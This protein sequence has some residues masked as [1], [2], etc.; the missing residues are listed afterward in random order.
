MELLN[1]QQS[2]R[3]FIRNSLITGSLFPL[4]N[5]FP[6]QPAAKTES[7]LKIYIFSK[8]LQF[9]DYKNM[10]EAA[11]EMGFDGV[12]LTVRPKGHVLPEKVE[13]DLPKAVEAMRKVGFSP[14]IM[15]TAVQDANDSTDQN[16]LSTASKLGFQYYRMNWLNYLEGKSIPDSIQHF[17]GVMKSLSELNKKVGMIGC[18]QNHAGDGMGASIWELWELL[19][20]ADQKYI[21]AEYDIRHAMVEGA[22]SW[23]S[24]LRLIAPHIKVITLKDFKWVDNNGV[25]SIEQTPLGEGMVDF[26]SYFSLLKQY[27]VDVPVTLH[28]EYPL[29]GA[30]DGATSLTVDKKVVF[31]AMKRDLNKARELL[32]SLE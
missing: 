19:R 18:Y 24:G 21:G 12:D 14:F 26:K 28:M 5:N 32:R 17:Q 3:T 20:T 10:A 16:V 7:R 13:S 8:H 9:L 25:S 1:N 11:A 2:R 29:G 31:D 27:K 22:Q 23:K 6:L 4:A 30:N 15:T